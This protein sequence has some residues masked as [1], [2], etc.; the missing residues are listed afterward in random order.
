M[1]RFLATLTLALAALSI[2]VVAA[3]AH[4]C[5]SNI[6]QDSGGW[7]RHARSDCERI[8]THRDGGA[9]DD[10]RSDRREWRERDRRRR[11]YDRDYDED[12]GPR[13]VQ[14]C[15]NV[16]PIRQCERECR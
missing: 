9:V 11:D 2:N 13:C 12:R 4:G 7:H 6:Q 8:Q 16:G 1:N 14:R 5:H 15:F 3:G 10:D